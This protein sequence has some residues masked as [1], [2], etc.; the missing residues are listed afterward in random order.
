MTFRTFLL[1]ALAS[2]LV[3]VGSLVSAQQTTPLT[4]DI[5]P[6]FEAPTSGYDYEKRDVMIPMRDGVKLHTVIV[7]PK[8][9]HNAPILLTRTP[10]NAS[11][12]AQRN[13]SPHMIS[14]LPLFDELFAAD[15]YIRVYQDV[16][17]K[18]GSE[19]EYVMTRPL[20]GPLNN[21]MVDHSTDA[22]DTI[23]WLVK[24]I[25]ES[26][27]R[28]GMVGSSYEGFTVVMALVNPH[29]ALK[30]ALPESP[31]I[32]G[33]M[34]DDWFHYGAFREINL[35]YFTEQTSARGEGNAIV[36]QGYDEYENFRRA[37]SA[38]EFAKPG[39]LEQ[40]SWWPKISEHPSY[41]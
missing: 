25:P 26:N 9:A 2:T 14:A 23:D 28:V 16:R 35:D 22:Y 15:G 3:L 24:N 38:G 34:G 7:V 29:P 21:S 36:R 32:D 1:L 40:L 33:W 10:Y 17:G 31:M 8:G 30:A 5:P 37:G 11:G 39:G 20:R 4:P 41:D 27:G 6:K 12:R 13:A 18:Y 19:G